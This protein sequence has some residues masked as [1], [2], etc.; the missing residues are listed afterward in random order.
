MFKEIPDI[1]E[2]KKLLD[3]WFNQFNISEMILADVDESGRMI[4]PSQNAKISS[5]IRYWNEFKDR[6]LI[7]ETSGFKGFLKPSD[8]NFQKQKD[9]Y[10][11]HSLVIAAKVMRKGDKKYT[12]F[13]SRKFYKEVKEQ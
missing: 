11:F 3:P 6:D 5:V 8:E 12:L 13:I 1:K 4:V 7:I 2:V 9:D 10:I